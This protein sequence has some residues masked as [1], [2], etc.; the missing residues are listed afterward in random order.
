[1]SDAAPKSVTEIIERMELAAEAETVTLRDVVTALGAASF[2]PVMMAPALAVVSP[3]SAIPIFPSICGLTIALV[4]VQLLF[5]RRH[6]W[7]PGWL[8]RRR[9]SGLALRRATGWLRKPARFLD[10][11]SRTRLTLLMRAPLTWMT[12]AACMLCG[13][14]MP[15][16]ELLP[17]TSSILGGA[18]TLF[19]LS[20]LVRDGLITALG[21]ASMLGAAAVG[22]AL[23]T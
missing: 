3:L 18:V 2:V 4:A 7:L 8:M 14:A 10:K 21:F 16:L 12:E 19:C 20:L 5:N 13:L 6:L 9:I 23:V 1:M 22:W 17:L 15:F 11:H